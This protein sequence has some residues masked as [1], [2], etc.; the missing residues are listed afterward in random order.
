MAGEV[1][2]E[3]PA[4]RSVDEVMYRTRDRYRV[5]PNRRGYI[6]AVYHLATAIEYGLIAA[7]IAVTI[8]V[9]VQAL[10]SRLYGS[11]YK[12]SAMPRT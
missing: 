7:G 9:V 1:W 10:S 3:R 4:K 8:I 6:S 2:L 11:L 12:W 5:R